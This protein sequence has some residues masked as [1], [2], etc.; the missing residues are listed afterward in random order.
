MRVLNKFL[1]FLAWMQA[2][3]GIG[4]IGFFVT[5]KVDL[6]ENDAALEVFLS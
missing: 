3:R 5:V 2:A 1:T 6:M 4:I